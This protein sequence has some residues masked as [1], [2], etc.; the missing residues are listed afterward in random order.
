MFL[1]N[2]NRNGDKSIEQRTI[3]RVDLPGDRI[4]TSQGRET[5]KPSNPKLSCTFVLK[6]SR[7]VTAGLG[8]RYPI[9]P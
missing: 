2:L 3:S 1:D 4:G 7:T 6:L 9:N 5:L 8:T